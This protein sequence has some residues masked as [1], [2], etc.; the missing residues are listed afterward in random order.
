M[1]EF[2]LR[3]GA[4]LEMED[5]YKRTPLHRAVKA[6]NHVMRLLVNKG[7]NIHAVDMYGQTALHIAAEAGLRDDV[8]FLLGHGAEAE[9]KDHKGRTPLDLAAKAGEVEVE[10]LL[11]EMSLVVVDGSSGSEESE[12]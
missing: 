6:K 2:L 10:E 8:H 3:N 5:D 4:E 9:S 1:V 7:A 12:G 11:H